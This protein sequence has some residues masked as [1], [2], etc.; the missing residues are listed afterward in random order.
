MKKHDLIE[1]GVPDGEAIG[2]AFNASNT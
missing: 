1:L 2:L